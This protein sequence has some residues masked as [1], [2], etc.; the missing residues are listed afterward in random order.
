[1]R[2]MV[3]SLSG[4]RELSILRQES[5]LFEEQIKRYLA[6]SFSL[7]PDPAV[8]RKSLAQ[9][10]TS[11]AIGRYGQPNG[12]RC[13]RIWGL[14]DEPPGALA[15][16]PGNLRK[17]AEATH[18]VDGDKRLLI[19]RSIEVTANGALEHLQCSLDHRLAAFI[20]NGEID[21]YL[22]FA[23]DRYAQVDRHFPGV[24]MQSLLLFTTL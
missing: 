6:A 16:E 21:D 1:M 20:E 18:E 8:S 19:G 24:G 14:A 7:P 22:L 13:V 5:A 23:F 17:I 4:E 15:Q 3:A 10:I 2:R 9:L 11:F 12:R